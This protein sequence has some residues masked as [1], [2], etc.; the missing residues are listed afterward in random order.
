[1]VMEE[2]LIRLPSMATGFFSKWVLNGLSEG[3]CPLSWK[4]VPRL[5]TKYEEGYS[6]SFKL[7]KS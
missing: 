6:K 1:M 3:S 4:D 5:Q 2:D 7:L